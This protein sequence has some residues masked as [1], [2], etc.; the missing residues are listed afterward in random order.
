MT[1]TEMAKKLQRKMNRATE[2]LEAAWQEIRTSCAKTNMTCVMSLIDN[3]VFAIQNVAR[4]RGI[5]PQSSPEVEAL[6]DATTKLIPYFA[7]K[8]KAKL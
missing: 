5:V 2:E 3:L 4:A 1:N 7:E 8:A 6:C